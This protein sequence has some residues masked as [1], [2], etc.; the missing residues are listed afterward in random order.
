MQIRLKVLRNPREIRGR[1]D[2]ALNRMSSGF[3]ESK[4][5]DTFGSPMTVDEIVD[6]ILDEVA[7]DGDKAVS[8]FLEI[9]DGVRVSPDKLRV[10]DGEFKEAAGQ[11]PESVEKGLC[12]MERRI[13]EYAEAMMP[14][15]ETRFRR[16]NNI[17]LGWRFSAVE[18][19][20]A[21]VP[22][23]MAGITPLI[24]SV[25]MNLVPAKVAGVEKITVATPCDKQGRV[26]P[27]ILRACEIAGAQTVYRAGGAQGVAAL[28][29]GTE[30]I[31]A[32]AKLIGPGN[33]FTQV[34]KR[35]LFARGV[36][37]MDMIAGP[38]EIA[39]F[40][41]ESSDPAVVAADMLGQA[42]HD[43]M[44]SSIV[45]S[46]SES[47]LDAVLGELSSQLE[48]LPKRDIAIK[49]LEDYGALLLAGDFDEACEL[50][51]RFAPEH[52]E[53]SVR[54][55]ERAFQKIRHAGAVFMGHYTPEVVG[56]YTA[57]PSHTLPTCGA[58][59]FSSGITVYTFLK[60]S[61]IVGYSPEALK[62]DL[63]VLGE[64]ARA[65]QLEAHA[66][67]AESR[68]NFRPF[69]GGKP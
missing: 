50:I 66:R 53:L 49:S 48:D 6:K 19:V 23:G 37:D 47:L 45:V 30:S 5:F 61:S 41:D 22:G 24:S 15:R 26:H 56:D 39:I 3:D 18:S 42:E 55:P 28:G 52:L 9:I 34:A 40:A 63:G 65:E 8:R 1:I 35:Q 62:S 27:Y 12:L 51:N 64:I 11:I 57:G 38:S 31:P 68:L 25:L 69:D 29:L 60:S 20:G 36:A 14:E 58:A 13:R 2:S 44:A 21:Y 4:R 16:E 33:V 7:R 59:K 43:P 17:E 32:G 54:E 46:C 67:S 10:S